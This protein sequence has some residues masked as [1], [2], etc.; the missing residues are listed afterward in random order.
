ME[1]EYRDGIT[2]E[3]DSQLDFSKATTSYLNSK[4]Y[5]HFLVGIIWLPLKRAP[6]C[7]YLSW[8]LFLGVSKWAT[9]QIKKSHIRPI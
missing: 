8:P 6:D 3:T 1:S 9:S 5:A 4:V 2:V 7:L